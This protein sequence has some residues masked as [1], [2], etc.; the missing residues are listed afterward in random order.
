MRT[1]GT[2]IGILAGGTL[3]LAGAGWLGLHIP[4]PPLPPWP[5]H[6]TV[7]TARPV[8]A[9][10]PPPVARFYTQIYP[11]G[12][13]TI[14]TAV[15]TGRAEM[16]LGSVW[17]PAR[18][19]F[20]HRAGQE[21]RHLIQTGFF[22]RPLLTVNEYYLDG[23]ARLELPC[24]VVENDPKTDQ[25][26]NL[27]LWAEALDFPA[28][29]LTDP[30]ARWEPIDD[31]TARLVIPFAGARDTLVAHFDRATGLLASL[32]AARWKAPESAA[33]TPWRID[34]LA[35]ATFD[36]QRLPARIA[37][38]WL[39]DDQ[40]WFIMTLDDIA[41]NVDVADALRSHAP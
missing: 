30:R 25:A 5:E 39:D 9:D 16:R 2:L 20:V 7:A 10:L 38:H 26:A 28:V 33:P 22:G 27:V 14:E 11:D 36:G 41:Y 17:M 21:Y 29:Y 40:P 37:V 6:P 4:P 3:A 1:I 31:Q 34:V 32:E 19:R 15:M 23:R 35:W 12:L 8:P 18:L 24:R 13:P